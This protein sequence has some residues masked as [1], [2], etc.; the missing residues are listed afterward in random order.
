LETDHVQARG[1]A[2]CVRQARGCDGSNRDASGLPDAVDARGAF[3]ANAD[4][5]AL[6]ANRK[7]ISHRS[8]RR[9]ED[10]HNDRYVGCGV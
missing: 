3:G 2:W 7:K 6:F 8:D 9:P 10:V 4:F 5:S 1:G